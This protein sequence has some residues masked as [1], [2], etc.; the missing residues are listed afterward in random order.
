[1]ID[2]ANLFNFF[3]I[4][5]TICLTSL[6]VA[7]GNSIAAAAAIKAIY[8]QPSAQRDIVKTSVIGMAIIETSAII[9]LVIAIMLFLSR[10]APV[11]N[12][13]YWGLSNLGIAAAI[14]ITGFTVGIASS[15]PVKYACFA[16]ARQPF[17]SNKILNIMLLT[18]SFIQTSVIFGFIIAL[19]INYQAP[20][21]STLM[22]SLRH[23][24][25]GICMGVGCIGPA[26]GLA[27]FAKS[28]CKGI[29]IN[30]KAYNEIIITTSVSAAIIET[31]TV[32]AL[33]ISLLLITFPAIN[34]LQAAAMLCAGICTGISNI[35]PGISSGKT[36]SAA[37]TVIANKPE[38]YSAI[39][40]TSMLAQVFI[41]SCAI[42]G[43]LISLL[44]I[45]LVK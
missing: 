42:Y 39:S 30:T 36:A 24:G 34:A 23:L 32:F 27:L 20:N 21:A 12:Q 38:N 15:F 31:A 25:S 33:I 10:N 26:I 9:G 44:L 7:I 28:A 5:L 16:V 2:F 22:D 19:L 37:C 4:A 1:M 3:T 29:G 8:I 43:F 41:D 14:C 18:L 35:A 17:F 6:G 11:T 40:R 13:F 45:F